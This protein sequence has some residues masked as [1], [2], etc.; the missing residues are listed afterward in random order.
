M[1]LIEL[2]LILSYEAVKY[3]PACTCGEKDLEL[4]KFGPCSACL[5]VMLRAGDLRLPYR[6]HMRSVAN[7]ILLDSLHFAE[8]F[9]LRSVFSPRIPVLPVI[10]LITKA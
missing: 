3:L 5:S 2:P 9:N 10:G 7:L 4:S 6:P 8:E 1:I